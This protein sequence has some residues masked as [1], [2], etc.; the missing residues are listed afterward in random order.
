MAT[1]GPPNISRNRSSHDENRALILLGGIDEKSH[2]WSNDDIYRQIGQL[3]GATPD[4]FWTISSSPRTPTA[5]VEQLERKYLHQEKVDFFRFEDTARGWVE[6]QYDRN[7]E[8]WVTADSL[9]MIYE[10]LTAGCR[11][12]LLP[13]AWKNENS[14]FSRSERLLLE[15]QLVSTIDRPAPEHGAQH[16]TVFNEAARC[17]E[18]IQQNLARPGSS[19]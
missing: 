7:A 10:G 8:V 13:V 5:C 19:S 11:V 14:K 15:K 9:S 18:A 17:A 4:K 1:I 2:H 12:G 3:I 6:D 16:A